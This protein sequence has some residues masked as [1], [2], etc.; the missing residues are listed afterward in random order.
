MQPAFVE[1]VD[2][3]DQSP[4]WTLFFQ[5]VDGRRDLTTGRF[6]QISR[7]PLALSAPPTVPV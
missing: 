6:N 7:E 3:L 4:F 1:G 2:L 5:P